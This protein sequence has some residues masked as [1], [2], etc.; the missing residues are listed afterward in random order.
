[1]SIAG[2][3]LFFIGVFGCGGALCEHKCMLNVVSLPSILKYYSTLYSICNEELSAKVHVNLKQIIHLFILF[4]QYF[5]FLGATLLAEIGLIIYV[6][7]DK[8]G[9]NIS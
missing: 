9:V 3:I 4:A 1:M 8:E 5:V 2:A 6:T 7:V